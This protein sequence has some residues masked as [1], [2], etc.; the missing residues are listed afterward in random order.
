MATL[1]TR[2]QYNNTSQKEF[3]GLYLIKYFYTKSRTGNFCPAIP[4]RSQQIAEN[5]DFDDSMF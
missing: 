4:Y 2:L 5:I 3:K 1:L